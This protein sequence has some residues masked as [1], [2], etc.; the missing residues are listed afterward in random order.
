MEKRKPVSMVAKGNI[1]LTNGTVIAKGS[2]FYVSNQV[3]QRNYG[4]SGG[5]GLVSVYNHQ[6]SVIGYLTKE[7]ADS[8]IARG[9]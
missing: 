9:G 5:K 6:Y 3:N 8:I 1:Q 2:R 7:Q 4:D